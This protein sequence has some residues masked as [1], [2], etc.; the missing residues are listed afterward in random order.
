MARK[1]TG[2][3]RI[4]ALWASN[5]PVNSGRATNGTAAKKGTVPKQIKSCN[6]LNCVSSFAW[7]PCW[8]REERCGRPAWAT[9]PVSRVLRE[10]ALYARLYNP[11]TPIGKSLLTIALSAC[12]WI[13]AMTEISATC[14]V[15]LK[16]RDTTA[17]E[18]PGISEF[19]ETNLAQ[20]MR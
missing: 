15:K 10:T 20:T 13:I 7:S 9:E 12:V 14:E 19:Q 4:C 17:E 3:S 16:L 5:M 6:L 8:K 18:K 11:K 2:R 1:V